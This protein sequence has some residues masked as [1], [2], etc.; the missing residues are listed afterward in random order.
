LYWL[1]FAGIM[2]LVGVLILVFRIEVT[3]LLVGLSTILVAVTA[4]AVLR[5][6]GR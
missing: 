3:G 4:E 2:A 1:K 5:M 6:A